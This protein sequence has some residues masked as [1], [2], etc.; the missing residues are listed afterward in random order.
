MAKAVVSEMPEGPFPRE[1]LARILTLAV[2]GPSESTADGIQLGTCD[3]FVVPVIDRHGANFSLYAHRGQ[4]DLPL[5]NVTR[6]P[7]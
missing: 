1:L 6:G 3:T 7:T 4:R 2:N 5:L